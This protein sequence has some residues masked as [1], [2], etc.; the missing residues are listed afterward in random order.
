MACAMFVRVAEPRMTAEMTMPVT[1][2]AVHVPATDAVVRAL[3]MPVRVA[4]AAM[5]MPMFVHMVMRRRVHSRRAP[6]H[7]GRQHKHC[8]HFDF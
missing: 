4:I 6:R 1:V 7:E 2:L 8:D 5:A 3:A